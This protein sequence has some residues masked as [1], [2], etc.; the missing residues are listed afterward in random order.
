MLLTRAYSK[1]WAVYLPN[2]CQSSLWHSDAMASLRAATIHCILIRPALVQGTVPYDYDCTGLFLKQACSG[3]SFGDADFKNSQPW[4]EPLNFSCTNS[5]H[6]PRLHFGHMEWIFFFLLETVF[7]PRLG[8]CTCLLLGVLSPQ[9]QNDRRLLV[10]GLIFSHDTETSFLITSQSPWHP[11][12]LILTLVCD[13]TLLVSHVF[14]R[15]VLGS[16]LYLLCVEQCL[17]SGR[18]S[19]VGWMRE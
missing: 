15:V 17:T 19:N 3:F 1:S 16:L 12:V 2:H 14:L 5:K 11:L 18:H 9:Y 13:T 10:S 4:P 8:S 6:L 7:I